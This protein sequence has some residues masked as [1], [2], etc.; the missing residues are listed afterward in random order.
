MKFYFQNA[1]TNS[2]DATMRGPVNPF[3]TSLAKGDE[4]SVLGLS[5]PNW[6]AAQMRGKEGE[7]QDY[8]VFHVKVWKDKP[9]VVDKALKKLR[10][11]TSRKEA[12]LASPPFSSSE[13]VA[14]RQDDRAPDHHT[15]AATAS[16]TSPSTSRTSSCSSSMATPAPPKRP[17]TTP[18]T[19]G[20]KKM[21]KKRGQKRKSSLTQRGT[22]RL[23]AKPA[24][25]TQ[26]VPG[27]PAR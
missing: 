23:R 5:F 8:L 24:E 25:E 16:L 26:R 7:F 3:T 22:P 14:S 19:S 21:R 17:K 1:N 13:A 12:R 10:S 4:D 18:S 11:E 2:F 6:L 9:I 20:A 15:S 27:F